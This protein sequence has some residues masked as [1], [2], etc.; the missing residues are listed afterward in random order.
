MGRPIAA[1]NLRNNLQN[2]KEHRIRF[3]RVEIQSAEEIQRKNPKGG[4]EQ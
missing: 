2:H 1:L 4:H 3:L